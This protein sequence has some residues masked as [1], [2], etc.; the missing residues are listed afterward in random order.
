MSDTKLAQVFVNFS[1]RSMR[2][3]DNEGYEK[4]VEWKWDQE[5]ADGFTETVSELHEILDNEMITYQFAVQ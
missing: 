1:K 2:I 5:G 3:M 4:T